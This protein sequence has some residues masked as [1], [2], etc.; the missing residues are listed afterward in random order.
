MEL[1]RLK[2]GITE[3]LSGPSL[4]G[5]NSRAFGLTY[6]RSVSLEWGILSLNIHS[7]MFIHVS[8]AFYGSAIAF[9]NSKVDVFIYTQT[10]NEP[11]F[12]GGVG[13]TPDR[14]PRLS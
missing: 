14:P 10:G 12:P 1:R 13:L 8:Q 11:K 5:G 9:I 7:F 3:K 6:S 2:L 4:S